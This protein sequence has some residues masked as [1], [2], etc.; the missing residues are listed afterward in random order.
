MS[1]SP[2]CGIQGGSGKTGVLHPERPQMAHRWPTAVIRWSAFSPSPR[3]TQKPPAQRPSWS[4]SGFL[5]PLGLCSG[6]G[7]ESRGCFQVL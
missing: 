1:S 7:K 2:A 6:P 5:I 3:Q 4:K